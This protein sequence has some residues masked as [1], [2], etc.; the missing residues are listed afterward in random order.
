MAAAGIFEYVAYVNVVI[1]R[2]SAPHKHAWLLDL[3]VITCTELLQE[4]CAGFSCVKA[5][6]AKLAYVNHVL[7]VGCGFMGTTTTTR[8]KWS[9]AFKS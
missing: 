3:L 7:E 2:A 6:S 8:K 5:T 1:P 4:R 9:Q